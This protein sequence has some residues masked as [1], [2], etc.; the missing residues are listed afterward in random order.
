MQALW[1]RSVAARATHPPTLEVWSVVNEAARRWLAAQPEEQ[2]RCVPKRPEDCWLGVMHE[3]G[4]LRQPLAFSRFGPGVE[5]SDAGAVVTRVADGSE[6][7]AV[8]TAASTRVMR[9]GRLA[10][11][12]FQSS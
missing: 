5:L 2:L 9:A 6:G 10:F 3:L 8:R 12:R 7:D 1:L 11:S 4:Q